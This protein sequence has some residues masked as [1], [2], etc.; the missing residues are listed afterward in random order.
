MDQKIPIEV[1]RVWNK[2]S[3]SEVRWNTTKNSK[4]PYNSGGEQVMEKL[5]NGISTHRYRE[6]AGLAPETFRI[7]RLPAY[8]CALKL[9]Q[10][11]IKAASRAGP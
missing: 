6:C 11:K 4:E 7:K 5:L 8:P 10:R 2:L 3:N 9:P 1:P